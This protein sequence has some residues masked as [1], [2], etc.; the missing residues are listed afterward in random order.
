MCPPG[1]KL[2]MEQK[3]E[4]ECAARPASRGVG[5]AGGRVPRQKN[6]RRAL[7]WSAWRCGAVLA[8]LTLI[9]LATAPARADERCSI[10]ERKL[11]CPGANPACP[12]GAGPAASAWPLFQHDAQHTGR[13]TLTGP[14]CNH[15][16]WRWS[17]TDEFLSAPSVGADGTVYVG[18]ARAPVCA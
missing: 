11:L 18:T 3:T 17:A 10:E 16:I 14:T 9:A 15:V 5:R 2:Q 13:S 8:L 7:L 12:S 1:A 4:A 6:T